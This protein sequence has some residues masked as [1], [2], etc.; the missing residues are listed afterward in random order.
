MDVR[1]VLFDLDGT[2]V[3]TIADIGDAM[4]RVLSAFG[5][6][7]HPT[8]L[9]YGMVG[10]GV[11]ELVRRALPEEARKS[12]VIERCHQ[13]MVR[14]YTD[15][16]VVRS[17]VYPDIPELLE[18]LRRMGIRTAVLSNKVDGITQ[19]VVSE[20]L[21][22]HGFVVVRGAQENRPRKPDPTVALEIAQSLQAAPAS[23]LY[24]GDSGVDMETARRAGMIPVGALWGF[25]DEAELR[26]AG[27]VS[28]VKRPL[29]VLSVMRS[30]TS[31]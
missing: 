13:E 30:V 12:D 4:N 17:Q 20:L 8:S 22:H 11:R 21:N 10:W 9:Y 7:T 24:L 1:A 16:P 2:L 23:V 6:P 31:D 15:H 28:V 29:D 18:G 14:E 25:R 26:E 27:A 3:D 19:I 5:Y